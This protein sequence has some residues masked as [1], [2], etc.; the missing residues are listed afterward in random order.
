MKGRTCK[1]ELPLISRLKKEDSQHH[2]PHIETKVSVEKREERRGQ[3]R[4]PEQGDINVYGTFTSLYFFSIYT[5]YLVGVTP[6]RRTFV[7]SLLLESYN[8]GVSWSYSKSGTAE[9]FLVIL[10]QV[11]TNSN[12]F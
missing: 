7:R 10:S 4:E 1:F 6:S 3:G 8:F 12:R 9:Q 2:F 5:E 11:F